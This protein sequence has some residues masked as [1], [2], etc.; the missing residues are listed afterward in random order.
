MRVL[1]IV[2]EVDAGPGVFADA[3]A[4]RGHELDEWM[5]GEGEIRP[6][7]RRAMAR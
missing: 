3:V 4:A 7:I 6:P 5:S 1:A 2:Q